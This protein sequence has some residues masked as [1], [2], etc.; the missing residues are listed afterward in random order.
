M[1]DPNSYA[2]EKDWMDACMGKLTGEG[3]EPDQAVAICM[4]M[5]GQKVKDPTYVL[6]LAALKSGARNNS[7]DRQTIRKIR[8]LAEEIKS[9]TMAMEPD[10][11]DKLDPPHY[12]SQALKASILVDNTGVIALPC[13]WGDIKAAGEGTLEV[14]GIPFGGPDRGRD[15]QGQYFSANTKTYLDAGKSVPV[16]YYHGYT[17]A[18]K[19]QGDPVLIGN[20]TYD[21][22]DAR[23]HWFKVGL[24]LTKDLARKVWEAAKKGLAKASSGAVSHLVRLAQDGE[25]LNWVIGELSVFDTAEGK[26]PANAYAVALPV[27]KSLYQ[28]AGI[29]FPALPDSGEQPQATPETLTGGAAAKAQPATNLPQAQGVIEMETKDVEKLVA[30][31]I[32]ANNKQRAAT[33]A[34][35]KAEQLKVDEAVKAA[36]VEWDKEAAKSRRLPVHQAPYLAQFGET[37][38]YDNLTPGEL[39]L[40]VDTLKSA[41]KDV[42]PAALKALAIKLIEDKNDYGRRELGPGYSL[43]AMKAAGIDPT[44]E[45]IKTSG[46]PLYTGGTTDG[47]YW[48]GTA[49]ARDL[50]AA[51]RADTKIVS[52]IPTVTIPDGFPAEA[53]PLEGTDPTWY[54]VDQASAGSS[55]LHVPAATVTSSQVTTPAQR[56]LSI[57]KVGARVLYSGE[58][59]EDS[60]I[61]FV[62]Q[63]RAQIVTS[64]KE[65][66]EH[67]IID[68]DTTTT[69]YT[70]INDIGN[71]AAVTA[72]TLFLGLDGFRHSALTNASRAGG[73]LDE[74]DYLE[75]MW[76]LGTAGLGGADM[77]KC[78]F[79]IDPNVYKKSLMMA[80]LKTKDVWSNATIESG[81]LTKLWGYDVFPSWF[82]HFKSTTRKS[83]SAGKVDQTTPGN[84]LYGAILGVR[85]DQWKLGYKR[86]M[87]L[88]TTRIANA[89]T[90]EIVALCRLGLQSRDTSA[91]GITYGLTV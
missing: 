90:W 84:N 51:I 68:G 52:K 40:V 34:A 48:T 69:A 77:Q 8:T 42:A 17:S 56:T 6:D 21:R 60:L 45:A 11:E 61:A 71:S 2:T 63:L 19:P 41:N 29:E 50:W 78:S 20:A 36:K 82:M 73:T 26:T 16:F 54:L 80:S 38:K 9:H 72:G 75:T 32:E 79:V 49:Y 28:F 62:P 55:T 4:S 57:K 67:L 10:D 88:E 1:P 22:T 27:M 18:G 44:I 53:F 39:G 13:M 86:Q 23:G 5:W 43:Q 64:G 46:D 24:D 74:D 81:V 85:W 66:I 65:Q 91:S 83:N 89:D 14:L 37:W 59:V 31:A 35:A 3:K 33:E 87:T 47:A 76:L 58:M 12:G 70:N 30:D 25:I 7:T 15:A